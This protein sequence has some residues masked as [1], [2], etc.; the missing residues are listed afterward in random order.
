MKST[1]RTF[2]TVATLLPISLLSGCGDDTT[3]GGGGPPAGG[4][5]EPA[6]GCPSVVSD[7]VAF[8]DQAGADTFALRIS[9]LT[10][11]APAALTDTTVK[12]LL[13][14]G[15]TLDDGDSCQSADGFSLFS[16]D[17]TFNWILQFDLAAG[18][19]KTG[20][21][22]LQ[23]D[24]TK[25]YC[26]LDGEIATFDVAPLEA[27]ITLDGNTFTIDEFRDVAV[28]IFTDPADQS[29]VIILPLRAV[30]I[31]ETTFSEDHNCIG[32]LNPEL[33]PNNLC[34]P[35]ATVPT[36]VDAG[37]LDGYVT[38][39][40]ADAVLV[41]ELGNAS[42]CTLIAGGDFTDQATKKCTRDAND[43]ILFEGD[44]C[45]GA[46]EGDAGEAASPSCPGDAVQLKASFSASGATLS[47]SC[48]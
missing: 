11:T 38:L 44:W 5:C 19:L 22:E 37:N 27:P 36:F 1:A 25:P 17:G 33:D 26:F 2:I 28:P 42:L 29:K 32:T 7:C 20:G 3:S 9:Q 23:T 34:L 24:P 41:P 6:A 31:Y 4:S 21:A 8:A 45:A 48:N 43:K 30:R 40:D 35:S 13:A 16:G 10:V 46:M 18:T 14:K 39:E 12:N 15:V 47:D